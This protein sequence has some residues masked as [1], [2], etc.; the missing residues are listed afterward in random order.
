VA[1]G[2]VRSRVLERLKE[3]SS[4]A[5][6][7][8]RYLTLLLTFFSL[9]GAGVLGALWLRETGVQPSSTERA[10]KAI[11]QPAASVLRLDDL[12]PSA[13]E[14][15]PK[16]RPKATV[17]VVIGVGSG[18]FSEP[19]VDASNAAKRD[20]DI[21]RVDADK[22]NAEPPSDAA[23]KRELIALAREEARIE[24]ALREAQ[25]PAT[26]TGELIWPVRGPIT[27]PF[28]PRWGRLHA[29][30]D[31]GVPIG[32]PVRAAD[33]GRVI[34]RGWTGGYGN[35]VCIQHTRSLSTC[36]GHLSRYATSKGDQVRRGEV[37]AYSGN[38]GAS[39]GP[40]L[41]F[42]TRVSGKPVDPKRYL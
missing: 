17:P 8:R 34:V 41:H 28:G 32:T 5:W 30:M 33:A 36:Y 20:P 37:V 23:V 3:R 4:S 38:T 12:E 18:Q 1:G 27:S 10:G 2:T 11:D 35:F 7:T 42:E 21:V 6:P 22:P 19:N 24:A 13:R 26:G 31:I 40:H 25:G 29:G 16:A 15:A 39:S 9:V 14:T